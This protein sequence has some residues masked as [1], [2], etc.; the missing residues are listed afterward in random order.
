MSR[1]NQRYQPSK[2]NKSF[3]KGPEV[4]QENW[5]DFTNFLYKIVYKMIQKKY[6]TLN[7]TVDDFIDVLTAHEAGFGGTL[8]FIANRDF[9][10][11]SCMF[12]KYEL[13]D[14]KIT[15]D[16]RDFRFNYNYL[17]P[18]LQR[19]FQLI[20]K[21]LGSGRTVI[22]SVLARLSIDEKIIESYLAV[23]QGNH[24]DFMEKGDGYDKI[25][26]IF[27]KRGEGY[28]MQDEM[29]E[30]FQY[31]I[32]T[33]SDPI[34]RKTVI[35]DF[36]DEM[37]KMSEKKKQERQREIEEKRK[38]EERAREL[39][40]FRKRDKLEREKRDLERKSSFAL[41][42]IGKDTGEKERRDNVNKARNMYEELKE[43]IKKDMWNDE[44]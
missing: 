13:N 33:F 26:Y 3:Q 5:E 36:N 27:E 12:T 37:K 30:M 39:E 4:P 25:L 38:R 20:V 15:E 21:D 28:E 31:M 9:G 6:N 11:N 22:K 17:H 40:E 1:N 42:P 14:P 34:F 7:I 16:E 2:N 24:D 23:R 41:A 29:V 8:R 10:N 44:F 32:E 19:C 18:I 35:K 43:E